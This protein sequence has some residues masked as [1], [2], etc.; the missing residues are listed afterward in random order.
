MKKSKATKTLLEHKNFHCVVD[1]TMAFIGG[2]WK[3]IILWHMRDEKKRFGEIRRLIPD[4]TERMLTMQLR[5]L[6]NDGLLERK[7]YAEVPPRVEYRLSKLGK[8]IIPVIQEMAKW[9]TMVA[10]SQGRKISP[11]SDPGKKNGTVI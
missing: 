11:C 8:S 2:K 5:S 9:G 3:S 10:K 1:L 7:V 4:I 6:E